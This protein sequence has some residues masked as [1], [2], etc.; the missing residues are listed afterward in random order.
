MRKIT[1]AV[2]HTLRDEHA[3]RRLGQILLIMAAGLTLYIAIV[4]PPPLGVLFY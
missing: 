2:R 1:D 4:E 3:L